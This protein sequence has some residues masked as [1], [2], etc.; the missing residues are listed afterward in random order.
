M[1]HD[2]SFDF[3]KSNP[4]STKPPPHSIKKITPFSPHISIKPPI[5][6]DLSIMNNE[7][8]LKSQQN[9]EM[10]MI[11]SS[12]QGTFNNANENENN[13]ENVSNNNNNN[14]AILIRD[15]YCITEEKI[16]EKKGKSFKKTGP[17]K[18][19]SCKTKKVSLEIKPD[20]VNDKKA[21]ILYKNEIY[22]INN[23]ENSLTS[24][25][26]YK[27]SDYLD[28]I[29]GGEPDSNPS[30]STKNEEFTIKKTEKNEN[31]VAQKEKCIIF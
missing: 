21:E 18:K 6:Y 23:N 9:N 8:E 27:V 19:I 25:K 14:N 31:V 2:N 26:I 10:S 17:C 7:F 15:N 16:E 5:I 22:N 3:F 30:N 4:N 1:S 28:N 29:E 12:S 24:R 20:I 11:S 13:Q